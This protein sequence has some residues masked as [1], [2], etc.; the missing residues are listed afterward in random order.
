MTP[1]ELAEIDADRIVASAR[2]SA[3]LTLIVATV[4]SLAGNVWHAHLYGSSSA[5]ALAAAAVV[6]LLLLLGMHLV[7]GLAAAR[8]ERR[9]HRGVHRA[10]VIGVTVLIALVFVASFAALRDLLLRERF[11]SLAATLIPIAVDVAVVVATTALFSLDGRREPTAAPAETAAAAPRDALRSA[12]EVHAEAPRSALVVAPA[13]RVALRGDA[14]HGNASPQLEDADVVRYALADAAAQE[15]PRPVR[16]AAL[17]DAPTALRDDD[18]PHDAPQGSDAPRVT[19]RHRAAARRRLAAGDLTKTE[20]AVA[21]VLAR[22]EDGQSI[23]AIAAATEMNAR[24]VAKICSQPR[25]AAV[26]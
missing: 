6:P 12:P 17:H 11:D 25:L 20:N 10:A 16:D 8:R 14:L 3:W 7:A 22:R 2:R 26:H 19:D 9:V 15:D 24:T 4:A 1:A 13:A 21:E 23:A 18:A 5:A